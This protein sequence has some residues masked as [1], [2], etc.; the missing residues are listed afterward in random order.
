MKKTKINVFDLGSVA[1]ITRQPQ[2]KSKINRSGDIFSCGG[3]N[4]SV[5]K[6]N[7]K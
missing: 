4:S 6:P 3:P 7:S 5:K 2:T 1:K